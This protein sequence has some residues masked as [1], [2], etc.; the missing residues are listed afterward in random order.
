MGETKIPSPAHPVLI[1]PV[2]IGRDP[3]MYP[4][5]MGQKNVS[6]SDHHRPVLH[7]RGVT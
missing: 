5:G 4:L 1:P 2:E 7:F 6:S 3:V